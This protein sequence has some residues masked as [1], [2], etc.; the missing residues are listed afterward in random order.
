LGAQR[1]EVLGF[2]LAG[3]TQVIGAGI[4]IG[5]ATALAATRLM[6]HYLY[7]VQPRDPVVF[8]LC[9]LTA[10]IVA[11]LAAYIPARWASKVDPMVALRYE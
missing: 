10:L 5:L 8:T 3:S 1:N 11:L 7:G 6:A 9:C 2:I 4:L